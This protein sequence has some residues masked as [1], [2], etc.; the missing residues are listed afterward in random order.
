MDTEVTII[1]KTYGISKD[2]NLVLKMLPNGTKESNASDIQQKG[3]MLIL[4][5]NKIL[6]KKIAGCF[7]R[8]NNSFLGDDITVDVKGMITKNK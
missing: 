1:C 4:L 5:A 2:E 8:Y 6:K 7:I 3:D